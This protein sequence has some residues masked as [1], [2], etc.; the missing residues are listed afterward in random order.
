[1][2]VFSFEQLIAPI[3]IEDFFQCYWE[4]NFVHNRHDNPAYFDGVLT[5]A[6]IDEFLSQQNLI[7][8]GIKLT[9][10]GEI[11]P[12][13]KW[14]RSDTLLNGTIRMVTDPQKLFDLFNKGNTI[15]INSAERSIPRLAFACRNIEQ[16]LKFKVQA[17]IYITPPGSQGF[18]LHYDPHDIFLMQIKGPKTWLIYDSGEELPVSY[19][20]LREDPK[21][22][23]KF[24]IHSGDFLYIPRGTPH[25]AYSSN[26][27][28]IHVNF[29]LKPVYGFHLIE[30]LAHMAA[31]N[32]KFFRQT[33][34]HGFQ[35]DEDKKTYL[36]RFKEKL[37][38]L[39]DSIKPEELLKKQKDKFAKDQLL[40]FQGRLINSLQ[41]ENLTSET[42]VSRLNGFTTIH[43]NVQN[44][45]V[46]QFGEQKIEIPVFV[47]KDI[48][49]QDQPFRIGQI[50]GLVTDQGKLEIVRRL[51]EAGFLK[52]DQLK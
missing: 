28:T 41:L 26:S 50:K 36:N 11:V 22:I 38:E 30:K 34:P 44:V 24:D 12:S 17:N 2:D 33:I 18:A 25:E 9:N 13:E 23:S 4:K 10:R 32:A 40:N 31:D 45:W 42:I 5:I 1:M 7:P 29:S 46:I 8:E 52:I 15:I 21:L 19:H 35:S 14:T 20:A 43:E 3:I 27:S 37:N 39:I 51:I 47:E 49:M 48:F 16:E 6:D